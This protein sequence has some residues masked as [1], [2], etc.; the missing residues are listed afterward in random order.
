MKSCWSD[1]RCVPGG[2]GPGE[3]YVGV[4][5]WG[6]GS[7]TA[8]LS[9]TFAQDVPVSGV[10]TVISPLHG[11]QLHRE[12]KWLQS[13]LRNHACCALISLNCSTYT[14]LPWSTSCLQS[15]SSTKLH[16]HWM[17]FFLYYFIIARAYITI[18]QTTAFCLGGTVK[19]Q[20]VTRTLS[21]NTHNNSNGV[22][23]VLFCV[24]M[25]DELCQLFLIY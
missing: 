22:P 17:I 2:R 19:V 24:F 18:Q 3:G 13:Q 15:C 23:Q 9:H 10:N 12:H 1:R 11:L 14:T 16:I 4:N 5:E 25:L 6:G 21:G 7:N 8:V 20:S